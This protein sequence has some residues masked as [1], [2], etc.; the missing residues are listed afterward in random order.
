LNPYAIGQGILNLLEHHPSQYYLDPN[1][2][3]FK[4]FMKKR[5]KKLIFKYGNNF[6]FNH[7]SSIGPTFWNDKCANYIVKGF[8]VIPKVEEVA[9]QSRRVKKWSYLNK[10]KN[11]AYLGLWEQ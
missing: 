8:L 5:F 9:P 1:E 10:E 2:L 11:P 7:F 4:A 6:K 3:D